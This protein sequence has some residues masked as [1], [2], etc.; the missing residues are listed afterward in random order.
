MTNIFERLEAASVALFINAQGNCVGDVR[1]AYYL[2]L[3]FCFN[4]TYR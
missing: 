1:E 3:A 4:K 2:E